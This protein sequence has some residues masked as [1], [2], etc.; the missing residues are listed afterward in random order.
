MIAIGTLYMYMNARI[1]DMV[2]ITDKVYMK[3]QLRSCEI[4][5]QE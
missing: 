3:Y 1:S 2:I 5:F 4:L